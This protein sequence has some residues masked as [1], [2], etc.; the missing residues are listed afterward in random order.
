MTLEKCYSNFMGLV[1]LFFSEVAERNASLAIC[2]SLKLAI[3]W[4]QEISPPQARL[5]EI[6][7]GGGHSLKSN[8]VMGNIKL[9]W[10]FQ[11]GVGG[12]GGGWGVLNPKNFPWGRYA[13]FLEQHIHHPYCYHLQMYLQLDY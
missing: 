4:F 11:S 7:R 6:P 5:L 2:Q 1:V 9:S 10:N 8:F 3:M 12:G 13:Y